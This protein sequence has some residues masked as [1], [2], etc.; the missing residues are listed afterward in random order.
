MK[1]NT[2][3]KINT[4]ILILFFASA[5]AC[6]SVSAQYF[7]AGF[8]KSRI[9]LWFDASDASTFTNTSGIA[10]WKDKANNLSAIAPSSIYSPVLSTLNGKSLVEFNGVKVLNI[11]DNGLLD[12]STGYHLAQMV[13]T[14]PDAPT[15]VTDFRYGTY[16]RNS[17]TTNTPSISLNYYAS[18]DNAYRLRMTVNTTSLAI[19]Y[20]ASSTPDLRASWGLIEN[21]A[22][23]TTGLMYIRLNGGSYKSSGYIFADNTNPVSLGNRY[24]YYTNVHWGIGETVLIGSALGNSG[25]K[26]LETYLAWKWGAQSNLSPTLANLYN[27]S[28][29]A[30]FNNL[31]GIGMES[32]TDS[33]SSTGSSNGLGFMNPANYGYLHESGDYLLA[34]DNGWSGINALGGGFTNWKR[35]WYVTKTDVGNNGGLV[36][37]CFD[38]DASGSGLTVNTSVNNYYLIYNATDGTFANGSNYVIPVSSQQQVGN[39]NKYVFSV[40]VSNLANGFY[41]LVYAPKS[42]PLTNLPNYKAFANTVSLSAPRLLTPFSGNGFAYITWSTDSMNYQP[43]GYNIY[44][45]TSRNSLTLVGNT[46]NPTTNGYVLNGLTNGTTIYYC[47]KA[48][49]IPGKESRSSDTLSVN[50]NQSAAQWITLPQYAGNLNLMMQ[51]AP[52]TNAPLEYYFDCTAGGGHASGWQSSSFYT[53]GSLIEGNSYTYR[54][55]TRL[56]GNTTTESGW[57]A[58]AT[59]TVNSALQGGFAYKLADLDTTSIFAPLGIGPAGYHPLKQDFSGM[60]A[61]KHAPPFGVHPRLYCNPEDSTDIKNRFKNTYSGQAISKFIHAYTMLLQLG[62]SFNSKASYNI[63]DAYGTPIVY[64]TGLFNAKTTYDKLAAGDTTGYYNLWGNRSIQMAY[65]FSQEAFECWLFKGTTDTSTNTNYAARAAKLAK[66]ITLWAKCLLSDPVPSQQLSY[67]NRDRFGGFNMALTYDFIYPQMT[68]EQ[69]DTVRMALLAIAAKSTDLW[70][71]AT[72]SYTNTINWATFG[73]EIMPNMVLE[74]EPG[75]SDVQETALKTWARGVWIFLNYDIYPATGNMYEGTGKDQLNACILVAM[76]KRGY[77]MIGHPSVRS[78]GTRYYPAIIQPYGYSFLGTDLLGGTGNTNGSYIDDPATGAWRNNPLDILGLKWILPN[79]TTVDFCWRNYIQKHRSNLP[80]ITN[81]YCYPLVNNNYSYFNINIP[82]AIFSSDYFTTPFAN[83][84]Q[85]A[86]KNNKLYLDSLGGFAA[87]RSGFDVNAA[88]LFFHNRQDL[89]GHAYAN[90]NDIV[91]SALGRSWI[92]RVTTHAN[93]AYPYTY[94]TYASSCLLIND[95]GSCSPNWKIVA[96]VVPLAPGT[97][98]DFKNTPN[99]LTVAGDATEPYS[100]Q[101]DVGNSQSYTGDNPNLSISGAE[102]INYGLNHY[103][104]S[105]SYSCDNISLYNYLNYTT[106]SAI[107]YKRAIRYP[108]NVCQKVFRTVGM[109][110]M[111]KPFALIVDDAQKDNNVNNYKWLAQ[112]AHD[113]TIEST[114]VNTT[115][116]NYRNDIIL[117]EPGTTGNRRF[118]VRILNNTGAANPAIPGIIDSVDSYVNHRLV[119]ESNSIDPQFKIMLF[120]YNSGDQLPLTSWNPSHTIVTVN[121]NGSTRYIAFPMDTKGRTNIQMLDAVPTSPAGLNATGYSSQIKLSW[122]AAAGATGYNLYRSTTYGSGYTLVASGLNT[123]TFN[124][125]GLTAG[126]RY[127]YIVTQINSGNESNASTE[128]YAMLSAAGLSDTGDDAGIV[129]YPNPASN[130]LRIQNADDSELSV[131]NLVGVAVYRQKCNLSQFSMD[132]SAFPAG[133]YVLTVRKN[134]KFLNYQLLIEH[135]CLENEK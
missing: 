91:Y 132:V 49:L 100:Y 67:A 71:Y 81:S 30:Y 73:Y 119:I 129:V 120:A 18:P 128:A 51:A 26:I 103:R 14:Y 97:I 77:S 133:V 35:S 89:G 114:T 23:S 6:V 48:S 134:K 122:T 24:Q 54:I 113:L 19:G 12:P 105:P 92:S 55:K 123:T 108:F 59:V 62:S 57:S 10:T 4:R 84:A 58:P 2:L 9:N 37:L 39:T 125:S 13:Y 107:V 86:F 82:A 68:K 117:K 20:G 56:T 61:I 21:F 115:D 135:R 66:V 98:V 47:V 27:P 16:T 28:N 5:M 130:R 17:S 60:R 74:G 31:V 75:Y 8:S 118:L 131:V 36:S 41:T 22:S 121:N 95:M 50:P 88:T 78:F 72:P 111:S 94:P 44:A 85:T 79:D 69:Q 43:Y 3:T 126:V 32:A 112:I 110:Q 34:A 83:E 40:D 93:G 29:A 101:W 106:D 33:I 80:D 96:G 7:P 127:Y 1:K 99:L 45:G 90:K 124:D 38:F 65:V 87:L 76:A 104:Y 42:T 53:D 46:A 70:G 11:A 64:N 116:A 63:A 109:I 52:A 25:R 102:I 15:T